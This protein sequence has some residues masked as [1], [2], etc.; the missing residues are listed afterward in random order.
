MRNQKKTFVKR[1]C[2]LMRG[3]DVQCGIDVLDEKLSLVCFLYCFFDSLVH[4]YTVPRFCNAGHAVN[5]FKMCSPDE[6][7]IGECVLYFLVRARRGGQSTQTARP[8]LHGSFFYCNSQ[9]TVQ[10]PPR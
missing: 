3:N 8:R 5:M 1:A 4:M 2:I 7:S 9:I 10:R 6:C